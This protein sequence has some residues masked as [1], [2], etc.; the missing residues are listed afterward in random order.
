LRQS[1]TLGYRPRCV[2]AVR[3]RQVSSVEGLPV[4]GGFEKIEE[5]VARKYRVAILASEDVHDRARLV[6]HLQFHFR[7]VLVVPHGESM[8]IEGVEIRN[9]GS[10][11]GIEFRNQLLRRRSRI[12]KRALDLVLGSIGSL[13]SAPFVAVAALLI[14][15][16]D[17]R[18]V[19]FLQEREGLDGE[20]VRIRKLRT[21]HKDASE[22]LEDF[23]GTNPEARAEWEDRF[24]LA[25]D[26]R[27]LPYIG[28]VLRRLSV[29]ELPQLWQVVVGELSLVGP[30]PFPEYHLRK[31][32]SEFRRLRRR[33]RPGITGLWQV[34]SRSDGGLDEQQR[35][36]QYYI[37]NW[38]LWMD[39]YILAKTI[40]VVLSGRGAY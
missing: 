11:L 12:V 4:L 15:I 8:P 30:R 19:F 29:D 33:V 1:L 23:L 25:S 34:M 7:N 35:Y 14:W 27:F 13:L 17:G 24:K 36:D 32:S 3:G 9:L 26:P 18:P 2:L 28:L 38:S 22:R 37:R 5:L 20:V 40:V 6:E 21:M 39:V 10:V 16:T 31:F